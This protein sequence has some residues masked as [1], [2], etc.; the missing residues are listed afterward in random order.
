M[1]RPWLA[2]GAGVAITVVVA[3]LAWAAHVKIVVEAEHYYS[4]KP[5]MA[6]AAS[7]VASG[8]KYVHIPLRRP[9]GENESGPYDDGHALYRI[10]VPRAG[11]YRLWALTHWHDECGNSFFVIVDDTPQSWIGEDGTVQKWHWV[12]GKTYQLS[13]GVHTI[14][15]QNREDGAKLDQFMLTTDMRYVPT[16]IERET[17][18]YVIMPK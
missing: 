11:L 9:H 18:E 7:E 16:R 3:S 12:K 5:S 10:N 8:G 2:A 17:P 1:S 4:I 13:A 14:R 6:V 15:F